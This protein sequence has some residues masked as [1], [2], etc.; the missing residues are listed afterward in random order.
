MIDERG[1][2]DCY[3]AVGYA[4]LSRGDLTLRARGSTI[5]RLATRFKAVER[6]RLAS[7]NSG[8]SVGIIRL[9]VRESNNGW[10]V[11]YQEANSS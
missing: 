8:V 10:A 9:A 11:T 7:K 5:R 2:R 6:V 4:D 3:I 1:E